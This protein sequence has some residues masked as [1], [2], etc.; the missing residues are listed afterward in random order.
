MLDLK[1]EKSIILSLG[2]LKLSDTE[3]TF[4]KDQTIKGIHYKPIFSTLAKKNG[5]FDFYKPYDYL[6]YQL[7]VGDGRAG[8]EISKEEKSLFYGF[9][10]N[11]LSSNASNIVLGFLEEEYSYFIKENFDPS[12]IYTTAPELSERS[13]IRI[14]NWKRKDAK[15]ELSPILSIYNENLEIAKEGLDYWTVLEPQIMEFQDAFQGEQLNQ[16]CLRRKK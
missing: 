15:Y 7:V 16:L 9:G 3:Y 8:V 1:N 14:S 6:L 4:K 10:A 12:T 5:N 11:R 2:N 13:I